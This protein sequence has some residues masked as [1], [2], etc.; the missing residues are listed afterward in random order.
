LNNQVRGKEFETFVEKF[1]GRVF[2]IASRNPRTDYG[3]FDLIVEIATSG[4]FW[5][6]IGT[7]ALIECKNWNTGTPI[8]DVNEFIGKHSSTRVRLAFFVSA[9]GFTKDA[10]ERFKSNASNPYSALLVP[11]TGEDIEGVLKSE[12]ALDEFFRTCIRRI[13][14]VQKF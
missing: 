1:F 10:M 2:T 9:S 5:A 11:I 7:D 12:L 6:A 8:S 3:E 4:P 14:Y 13:Q